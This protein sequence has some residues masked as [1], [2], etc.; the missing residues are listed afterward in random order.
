MDL[1]SLSDAELAR[2]EQLVTQR[3]G[4]KPDLPSTL[5]L[6]IPGTD[7]R[8]DTRIPLPAALAAGMLGAGKAT[9]RI[10]QGIQQA[11]SGF[12]NPALEG[13]VAEENR[14][15]APVAKAHPIA[16]GLGES[17][18]AFAIPVG[19]VASLP[20][21]LARTAAASAVPG[22]LEYGTPQERA[23][24]AGLGAAAGAA[25]AG[26][27]YGLGRLITPIRPANPVLSKEA[28]TLAGSAGVPL[29]AGQ[30]TGS[31]PLQSLEGTLA[32][33]P[34]SA[35]RM[36]A[37]RQAQGEGFN[38][39]AMGTLGEAPV[40]SIAPDTAAIAARNI[41]GRLESA[42]APVTMRLGTDAVIN[43]L[44]AVEAKYMRNLSADQKPFIKNAIDDILQADSI[45]GLTYQAWRSR[46]G[47][48]AAST[49]DSEFKGALKG[50]QGALDRA[51][52]ASAGSDAS[53]AMK[54]ARGEWRNYKTLAPLLDKAGMTT[55]NIP[56]AQVATRA[57]ASKN[58]QGAV[59][60]LAQ[61]GQVIGKEYM[62]S[63]TA[64]RLFW[65]S[66]LENPLRILNPISSVGAPF[67]WTTAQTIT[68][69]PGI[70]YLTNNLMTPELESR[71]M[72]SGG[73]LGYAGANAAGL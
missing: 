41:G 5:S 59:G 31:K 73:L 44:A 32:T 42:A 43:D 47:A 7:Y 3:E 53:A 63:G 30:I 21:A 68:R 11:A 70:R 49:S 16:S 52:D 15:Y 26:A 12:N 61:L 20:A 40:S 33:F 24:R 60:D 54:A 28:E 17:L 36:A 71:L 19:A 23:M 58:T 57:L 29:T 18:P 72:R 46:I 13:Q 27:G 48:R 35:A 14:L 51:F 62:N 67:A 50:L 34:G 39:A 69:G 9:T 1:S 4:Q 8:L 2:L 22:A 56:A 65:Q 6:G 10:G 37:I 64:P 55:N 45:D 66:V 38:R 25:G